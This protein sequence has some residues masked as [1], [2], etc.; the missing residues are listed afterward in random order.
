VTLFWLLLACTIGMVVAQDVYPGAAAYHAGWYNALDIALFILGAWRL[1]VLQKTQAARFSSLAVAAFGAAI[2]VFTGVASGLMGP[3]THTVVGAPGASVRD[4]D[5][6]GSF[7]FPLSGDTILLQRGRSTVTVGASRRYT[8]A[9]ILWQEPRTVVHVDAADPRGG[10]LTITQPTNASFLSPV[11]LMQQQTVIDG[12]NVRFDSFSVP[13]AQR[14]VKAVLFTEQQAAQLHTDP[15]IV[16]EPAIL[17]AVADTADRVLPHGIGLA[18]PGV[19][20]AIGGLRL[21]ATVLS[22]PAVVVASA[23]YWPVLVVGL[24]LCLAGALQI[25]IPSRSKT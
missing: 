16:G 22:Y 9:F 17:F 18:Q 6:G 8:G 23:P 4:D 12:M 13:A 15:P 7:V 14:N 25:R 5:A 2:V 11:L 20:K 24:L 10:H 3:D 21:T 1:R 19:Q